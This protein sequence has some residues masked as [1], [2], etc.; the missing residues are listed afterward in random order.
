M[1]VTLY[2]IKRSMFR[3]KVKYVDCEVETE[4]LK[5]IHKNCLLQRVKRRKHVCQIPFKKGL[6][7][8]YSS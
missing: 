1:D 6:A 5:I 3:M 8:N 2:D 7:L 4:Y